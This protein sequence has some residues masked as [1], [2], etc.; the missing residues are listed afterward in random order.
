MDNGPQQLGKMLVL[1]AAVIAVAGLVLMFAGK[2]KLPGDIQ[3]ESKN[4]RVFLPLGT[5]IL[6]SIVL[7]LVF[8]VISWLRK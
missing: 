6:I 4:A 5:C 8:W 2:W 3:W 7:T 1:F